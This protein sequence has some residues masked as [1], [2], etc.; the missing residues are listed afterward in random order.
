MFEVS[1]FHQNHGGKKSEKISPIFKATNRE[2]PV[3]GL[4]CCSPSEIYVIPTTS[5]SDSLNMSTPEN[6]AGDRFRMVK[7]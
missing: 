7:M 1:Q 6:S 3:M 5:I 2:S 4:M